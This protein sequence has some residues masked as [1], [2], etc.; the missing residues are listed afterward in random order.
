MKKAVATA[1]LAPTFNRIELRQ[2][3]DGRLQLIPYLRDEAIG[4][5]KEWH[6]ASGL[7][8]DIDW[9]E[10]TRLPRSRALQRGDRTGSGS[11]GRLGTSGPRYPPEDR[12]RTRISE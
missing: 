7:A 2:D 11:A 10:V 9:T 12:T 3:A 5:W 1:P 6:D 8:S 4:G